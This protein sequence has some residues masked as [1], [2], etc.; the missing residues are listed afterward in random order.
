MVGIF[1]RRQNP[2]S[3]A[4]GA[5]G[6]A[7]A[8]E[9]DLEQARRVLTQME[10]AIATGSDLGLRT[11]A[12]EISKASGVPNIDY[13]VA[14]PNQ[15]D[16]TWRWLQAVAE[17]AGAIDDAILVARVWLFVIFWSATIE[18]E[19]TGLGDQM[20]MIGL[21]IVRVS[22]SVKMS[23]AAIAQDKIGE[24]PPDLT[25]AGEGDAAIT[26]LGLLDL[27]RAELGV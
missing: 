20:D 12:A 21:G 11:A 1:Q 6:S 3:A 18:P 22:P 9:P 4:H 8:G 10:H 13:L 26:A 25:I 7:T 27:A 5:P 2:V 15:Q 17:R 16:R 19:L 14:N 23:V 24:L